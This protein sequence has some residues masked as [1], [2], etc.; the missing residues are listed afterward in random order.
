MLLGDM[1]VT[2]LRS[3]RGPWSKL[4]RDGEGR[5]AGDVLERASLL[6]VSGEDPWCRLGVGGK[7][8]KPGDLAGWGDVARRCLIRSFSSSSCRILSLIVF[9]FSSVACR[10]ASS[11][12]LVAWGFRTLP[13]MTL[14]LSILML[15]ISMSRNG[16]ELV[17][18]KGDAAGRLGDK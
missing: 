10:R 6:G 15:G 14:Y 12:E 3:V 4:D 18:A 16:P 5:R 8:E 11:D 7:R 2:V 1:I 17:A 13:N 9:N